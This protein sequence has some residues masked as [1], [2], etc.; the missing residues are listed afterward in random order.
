ME[1]STL[2][3]RMAMVWHCPD[4]INRIVIETFNPDFALRNLANNRHQ[5]PDRQQQ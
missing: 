5:H 4:C 2:P 3:G 1:P